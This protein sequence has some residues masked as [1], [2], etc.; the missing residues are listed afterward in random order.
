VPAGSCGVQHGP[1]FEFVAIPTTPTRSWRC[2]LRHALACDG[3][4]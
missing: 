3:D 1:A 2:F 4:L